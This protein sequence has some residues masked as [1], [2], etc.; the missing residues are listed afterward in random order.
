MLRNA[1]GHRGDGRGEDKGA[2]AGDREAQLAVITPVLVRAIW[3]WSS[4]ATQTATQTSRMAT[5]DLNA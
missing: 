4:S 2:H 1:G 5:A 3:T